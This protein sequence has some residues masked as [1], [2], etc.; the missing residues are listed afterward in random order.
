LMLGEHIVPVE[1]IQSNKRISEVRLICDQC[2][3]P[4][5]TCIMTNVEAK[6]HKQ[7]VC[8]NCQQKINQKV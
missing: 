4:I 6:N 1:V 2:G 8:Q 3:K 5:G 7:I